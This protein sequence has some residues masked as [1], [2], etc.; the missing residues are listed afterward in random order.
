MAFLSSFAELMLASSG[1][2]IAA[3]TID[4]LETE[5]KIVSSDGDLACKSKAA[6]TPPITSRDT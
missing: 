5:V 2:W 1:T 3:S 6:E 4:S